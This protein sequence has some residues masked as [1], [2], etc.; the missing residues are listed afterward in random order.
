MSRRAATAALPR[1]GGSGGFTLIEL[2]IFIVVLAIALVGLAG[3]MARISRTSADPVVQ[4]R[5]LELA[6]KHMDKSLSKDLA[7][8]AD[9]TRDV[10]RYTVEITATAQSVSGQPGRLIEV[11]VQETGSGATM[12]LKSWRAKSL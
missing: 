8:L 6:Q 10:G 2:L 5:A 3:L 9:G 4:T 12:E 11:E 7:D 1:R